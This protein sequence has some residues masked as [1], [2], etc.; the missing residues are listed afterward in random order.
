MTV[1]IYYNNAV[2]NGLDEEQMM[3]LWIIS[4]NYKTT[5]IC[6]DLKMFMFEQNYVGIQKVIH[7][8]INTESLKFYNIP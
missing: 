1:L 4:N 6:K 2:L 8:Q 3:K 5:K 7:S